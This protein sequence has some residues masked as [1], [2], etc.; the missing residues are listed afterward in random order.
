MYIFLLCIVR[1]YTYTSTDGRG[2]AA[3]TEPLAWQR[4]RGKS[5]NAGSWVA[6]FATLPM[7]D[8]SAVDFACR[9]HEELL[10]ES[11]AVDPSCLV[12]ARRPLPPG[13]ADALMISWLDGSRVGNICRLPRGVLLRALCRH[14]PGGPHFSIWYPATHGIWRRTC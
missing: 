13:P 14:A 12:R 6:A 7:G 8:G 9:A 3:V 2:N 5:L 1:L 11:G 4:A 10:M